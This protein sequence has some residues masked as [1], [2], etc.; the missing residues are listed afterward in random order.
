MGR[1]AYIS[2]KHVWNFSIDAV[3][4]RLAKGPSLHIQLM[5]WVR[6]R[7]VY[8]RGSGASL[9]PNQLDKIQGK[10]FEKPNLCMMTSS[11]TMA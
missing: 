7:K 2:F 9:I 5:K 6:Y 10:R 8:F 3:D 11:C 4:T 1:F